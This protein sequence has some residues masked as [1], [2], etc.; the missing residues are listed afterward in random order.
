MK[1]L[2][3]SLYKCEL[4]IIRAAK[5]L[6][7]YT[8]HHHEAYQLLKSRFRLSFFLEQKKNNKKLSE[9]PERKN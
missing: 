5:H 4:I 8:T 2:V 1:K 6:S 9:Q 3:N 7:T